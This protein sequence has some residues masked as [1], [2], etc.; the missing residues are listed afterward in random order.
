MEKST[1]LKSLRTNFRRVSTAIRRAEQEQ[2][3][4]LNDII[5]NLKTLKHSLS[6]KINQVSD[7]YKAVLR[8][9]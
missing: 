6:T 4:N 2:E 1:E 3:S 8:T 9:A 5:K 7:E